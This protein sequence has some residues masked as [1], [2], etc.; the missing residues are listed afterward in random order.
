MADESGQEQSQ[1]APQTEPTESPKT[2]EIK[3]TGDK[4]P[5]GTAKTKP[6]I[7]VQDA[8]GN[9]TFPE[10]GEDAISTVKR[11]SEAEGDKGTRQ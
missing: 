3:G 4:K 11:A 8:Q 7:F 6:K 1:P 9:I 5:V 2:D 10:Q